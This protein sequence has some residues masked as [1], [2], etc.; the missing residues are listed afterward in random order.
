M[1]CFGIIKP[2]NSSKYIRHDSIYKGQINCKLIET[3]PILLLTII[4]LLYQSKRF[5]LNVSFT[6][7]ARHF[8]LKLLFLDLNCE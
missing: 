4:K 2:N 8:D 5:L 1:F 6:P 7:L 3:Q